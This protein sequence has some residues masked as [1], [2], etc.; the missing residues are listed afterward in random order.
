MEHL[1]LIAADDK[2]IE[3]TYDTESETDE[4]MPEMIESSDDEEANDGDD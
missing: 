1:M 3:D 2:A 4:E